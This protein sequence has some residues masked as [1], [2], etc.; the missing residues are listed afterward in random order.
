VSVRP[1]LPW[2]VGLALLAPVAPALAQ[3]PT[4][5]TPTATEAPAPQVATA[6]RS[7][8]EVD[9][10][11]RAQERFKSRMEELET[12]TRGYIDETEARERQKLAAGY[13]A[14]ISQLEDSERSQ[15]KLAMQRMEDFL[16][17]YPANDYSS[18]VRF[19]LADLHWE[20]AREEWLAASSEYYLLEEK[21]LAEGRDDELPPLPM[22]DLSK[23]V[24]LYE[25]IIAENETLPREQQYEFLDGA[26]YSLGFVYK[27][28]NSQQYDE[29][30][31]RAAFKKLIEVRPDS[32]L[33]DDAH[34]N[35]GNFAFEANEFDQAIAEYRIVYD[36]GP[37]G[38]LYGDA[39]YQLAWAYYKLN[40]YDQPALTDPPE[41]TALAMFTKLLDWSEVELQKTGR[42]SDY[43]P[44]A[45]KYMA[46]SFADIADKNQADP[47][48][49]AE[50]YFAK[51]GPR[52]YEWDVYVAL[53]EA[54]TQ[55]GRFDQAV[56]VYRKLQR[57]ERWRLKPDNPE[58]QMQVVKLQASGAYQD[59]AA[60][61]AARIELTEKY[62]D[63]SEWWYANRHNPEALGT[64]RRY[65][66]E[67]LADVAIEYRKNADADG[68][69]A[70]YKLAAE[71]FQEYLDKF[72]ISDDYFQME[73]YLADT[74]YRAKEFDRAAKE[75][76]ALVKSAKHHPYGDGSVY[77]AMRCRQELAVAKWG[78]TD[79]LPQG[80]AIEKKYTTQWAKEVTVYALSD[81]HKAFV[82]S[83]DAVMK[84]KFAPAEE[85]QPDWAGTVEQNRAALM[86]IGGQILHTHGQYEISRPR[87]LEVARGFPT[88]DEARYAAQLVIDSYLAEGDFKNV[89]FWSREFMIMFPEG[90]D[91]EGDDSKFKSLLEQSTFKLA[92][93][94]VGTD[95]EVAAEMFIAFLKDF[96][97]SEYA[98]LALY[99]AATSYDVI[100]RAEKAN[101]LYEQYVNKY[102]KDEK[103]AQLYF[104][105][106]SNYEST[107]DL[108]KAVDYYNRLL[109]NF[110]KD[111][112]AADAYYNQAFLKVGLGDAAGA[113][114]GFEE[115]GKKY[116]D[117]P[118]VEEVFFQAG[119]QWAKVGST[120]AI[121][122]YERYL[123]KFGLTN[124]DHALTADHKLSELYR[125]AGNTKKADAYLDRIMKDFDSVPIEKVG[126]EGRNH[127][128]ASAFRS[129]QAKYDVLVKEKTLPK[130]QKKAADLLQT[131][132]VAVEQFREE[133]L[134]MA[135]KYGDFEHTTA[136]LYLRAQ[137]I[138]Y[139]ANFGPQIMQCPEGYNDDECL[140]YDDLL[141][142]AGIPQKFDAL[143]EKGKT[144]LVKLTELA[145]EK[146]Q[147]SV[148]ISRAYEALNDLDPKSYPAE[149]QE[150][151]GASDSSIYPDI[152]PVEPAAKKGGQ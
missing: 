152:R 117:R 57:D 125:K 144:E 127:A 35:L 5:P 132:E 9:A 101:E 14:L 115:Y 142:Q 135:T 120:K 77:Q 56:N 39:M 93:E 145:R 139:Y 50:K 15:R 12:D 6:V 27:E 81:E 84:H 29:E 75:Y 86:Y 24:A 21:L 17:R 116:P 70:S 64:A 67:S 94:A 73:W 58:F 107:F 8:Q 103:S 36:K 22:M 41:A 114:K 45:I 30:K 121:E 104:R 126:V 113:A 79:K 61:A 28:E 72:P 136:V 59:L 91:T 97:D 44:D 133:A 78:P 74:L 37:E 68:S 69:P 18:H 147:H 25:R 46:F 89:Q 106:A 108:G 20:Q 1:Y 31:A 62:N 65:I 4:E 102:P 100:G 80:A 10:F 129:I 140:A 99:N 33:T 119:D 42:K 138:L 118:D 95:R 2:V 49:V 13:D 148:W 111:Q 60:S 109:T 134:A 40:R 131:K 52:E 130:D 124:P 143:F 96:P 90:G 3:E 122:F 92:M 66:E 16:V 128:A 146:K 54:L 32:P 7:P 48:A 105:I 47:T 150:L 55:Y 71:K 110:P 11:R 87:L 43:A 26:Y 137:A 34:L 149:K 88:K 85:G 23:P 123:D 19:R 38:R 51:V 151:R 98:N 76:D 83:L 82:A 141:Q 112:S 53:G 63:Q